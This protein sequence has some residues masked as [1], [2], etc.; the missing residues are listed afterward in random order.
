MEVRKLTV[1]FVRTVVEYEMKNWHFLNLSGLYNDAVLRE[2]FDMDL[3]N[4][5]DFK[6]LRIKMN[7]MTGQL[8]SSGK[9]IITS[10]T[11][12]AEQVI[13]LAYLFGKHMEK[14]AVKKNK[15]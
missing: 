12:A 11:L 8:F 6:C 1:V 10:K 7:G 3:D 15:G 9:L 5:S 2:V 14:F 13:E 4:D